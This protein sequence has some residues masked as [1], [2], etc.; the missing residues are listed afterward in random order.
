[1][2]IQRVRRIAAVFGAAWTLWGAACATDLTAYTEDWAPYNYTEGKQI[3]G[4]STDILRA[5]CTEAKL[6][7]E[8]Q[9]VP[10]AR[11]Y[12]VV[13]ATPNTILYTTARKHAREHEFL[14]LG[15]IL[16]RTTWIYAKA[17]KE[18]VFHDFKDLSTARIGVVR[19]DASQPDLKN[20]GMNAIALVEQSSN[21][22]VLKMLMNDM[23]DA[24]VDTEV[25]MAWQLKNSGLPSKTLTRLMKLSDEGAYYFALNLH[26]DLAWVKALDL[27]MDKLRRNGKIDSI[28]QQYTKSAN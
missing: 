5:A 10:W 14:W 9:M 23:V 20:A 4:I 1:M 21:A 25:S 6:N 8:F 19:D 22:D 27:A 28:V 2:T 26:T 13:S 16:P 18:K 17:G 24:M 11:A 15:P 7:C 12:K 3:K